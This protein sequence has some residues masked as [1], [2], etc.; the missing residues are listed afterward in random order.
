MNTILGECLKNDEI[1]I[2]H[3]VFGSKT[4]ITE[5]FPHHVK[6]QVAAMNGMIVVDAC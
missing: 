6:D 3:S 4:G 2:V 1:P 5:D